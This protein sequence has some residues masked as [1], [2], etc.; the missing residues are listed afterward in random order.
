M[1]PKIINRPEFRIVGIEVRTD[2]ASEMSG[3]GRIAPLWQRFF[4][5]N[6]PARIPDKLDNA[7]L[8]VYTDYAGDHNGE[9][10]LV[11]G[12]RVSAITRPPTGMVVKTVPAGRFAVFTS[13]KG[14][15]EKVVPATWLKVWSA[16][17]NT[18]GGDRAYV[19]DFE[20]YDERAANPAD[21]QVDVYIG[22][23]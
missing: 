20:V 5:E 12:A 13:E 7:I 15:A 4:Q 16:A 8:A 19:A 23:K 11:I 18:L 21:A 6:V 9:Y 10:T 22:I 1:D 2:N 3:A 17:K 14:P